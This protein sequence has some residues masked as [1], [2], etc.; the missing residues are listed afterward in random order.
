MK[1]NHT[2]ITSKEAC[3]LAHQIRRETGC[4]LADAFKMAYNGHT[5]AETK[6]H[7]T[8]EELNQIFSDKAAELLRKG[9]IID[10]AGMSGHQGE[11]GKIVFRK[12][13]CW[14]A[15]VMEE[16]STFGEGKYSNKYVI[17]FGK[18]TEDIGNMR[19]LNNWNTPWLNKFEASWSLEFI[20]ITDNFFVTVEEAK[21]MNEKWFNRCRNSRTNPWDAVDSKYFKY[22]LPAVRAQ[23]G[24]KSLRMSNILEVRRIYITDW[25][26]NKVTGRYYKVFTDKTD[27][28]GRPVTIDIRFKS[29]EK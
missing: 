11:I 2:N 14:Y 25:I 1:K 28:A 27:K 26:D 13:G 29:N 20:K 21:G 19:L 10:V 6:T 9:Y 23:K 15:L 3:I 12:D 5:K 18:Y 8:D 7:W 4:S 24:F 22:I 17:W 16:K